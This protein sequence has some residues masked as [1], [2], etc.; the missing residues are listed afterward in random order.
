MVRYK[1]I[2]SNRN[3]IVNVINKRK[4]A[5]GSITSELTVI[6]STLN[7]IS[8]NVGK[9]VTQKIP[10][11][12]KSPMDYLGNNNEHSFLITPT[13]PM[14]ISDIF[15]ML[16]IGKSIGPN[17]FPTKLL[18]ILSP[19]VSLPLSQKINESLQSGSFPTKSNC[20]K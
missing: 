7:K 9:N 1:E 2:I 11:T 10:R 3:S 4:G 13:I 14:E 17:S 5:N 12:M 6:V 18:N 19:H 8:I 15:S 16:K 20:P